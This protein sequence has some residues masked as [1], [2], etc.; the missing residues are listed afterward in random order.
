V[1]KSIQGLHLNQTTMPSVL[2][3]RTI[4][5]QADCDIYKEYFDIC[6]ALADELAV[7]V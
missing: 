5:S 7:R 3:E 1:V 6:E 4:D 2:L